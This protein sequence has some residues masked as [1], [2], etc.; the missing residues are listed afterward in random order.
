MPVAKKPKPTTCDDHRP[1]ILLNQVSKVMIGY[2][3][4]TGTA[5]TS[6]H[7]GSAHVGLEGLGDINLVSE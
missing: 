6:K 2:I 5:S 1:I 3:K 7:G 4:N